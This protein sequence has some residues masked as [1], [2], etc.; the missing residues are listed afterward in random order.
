MG[1]RW[2]E[3]TD[4]TGAPDG[5]ARVGRKI[6]R[7]F[8]LLEATYGARRGR[9]GGDP[10]DGLIGTILSQHTSDVN[11]GR[12]H[13]SLRAAF[14][15]WATVLAA[16]DEAV[17]DAI[18]SGGLAALKAR[19]IKEVLAR[20][21]AARGDFDLGFL[22]DLPLPEARAWLVAL[23]GVG[24]KTAACTLLF[25]LGRPALPV[26]TH[27]H[28]VTRR[29]GLIGPRVSAEAAHEALEAQLEPEQ[30]YSFHVNAIAHGRRV[31]RAPVPKCG[32]CPLREVCNY[33]LASG[34]KAEG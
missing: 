7:V 6:A 15:D 33:Y 10:L 5:E 24:P 3:T 21:F 30:I 27:V 31:C 8:A 25:N 14:P 1:E 26:D 22:A 12:A 9:P 20:V 34:L 23:P 28:R 18:R 32:V 16:P 13:R 2:D 4:R 17:A 19:R 11:S 29:L